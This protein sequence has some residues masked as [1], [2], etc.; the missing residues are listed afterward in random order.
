MCGVWGCAVTYYTRKPIG[1]WQ[2]VTAVCCVAVCVS[3]CAVSV[4]FADYVMSMAKA[5]NVPMIREI[6]ADYV[7]ISQSDIF[8][9][10]VTK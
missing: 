7:H 3:A 2:Y 5:K 4:I 10:G 6:R 9:S 8:M 1:L